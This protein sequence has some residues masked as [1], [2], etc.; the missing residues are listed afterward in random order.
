MGLS[1]VA[2]SPE[3]HLFSR[4]GKLNSYPFIQNSDLP[5]SDLLA[6]I[7]YYMSCRIQDLVTRDSAYEAYDGT[8]LIAIGIEVEEL[9]LDFL[10][11]AGHLLYVS[12]RNNDAE[13]KFPSAPMT[14]DIDGIMV[15]DTTD[16]ATSGSEN[17]C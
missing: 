6:A 17:S 8:A 1:Q 4:H 5:D 12:E 11:T 7:H 16:I 3:E 10:G 2:V 14:Q 13:T 9:L 15:C